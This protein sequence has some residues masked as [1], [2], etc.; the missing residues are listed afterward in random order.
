MT[1]YVHMFQSH[2]N[3]RILIKKNCVIL[4]ESEILYNEMDFC[5]MKRLF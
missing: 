3:V 5:I 4:V 1:G 2:C